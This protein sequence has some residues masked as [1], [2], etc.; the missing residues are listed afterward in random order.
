MS[1]FFKNEYKGIHV[2]TQRSGFY[3][4]LKCLV[5]MNANSIILVFN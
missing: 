3:I 4:S 1:P 5:R 2:K